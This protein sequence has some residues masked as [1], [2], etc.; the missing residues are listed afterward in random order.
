MEFLRIFYLFIFNLE[1]YLKI[2][3]Q[4]IKYQWAGQMTNGFG[5]KSQKLAVQTFPE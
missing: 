2:I 4:N 1:L 3:G 5:R